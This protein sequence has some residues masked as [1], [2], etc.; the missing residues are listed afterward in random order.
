M[1]GPKRQHW[2]PCAYLQFFAVDANYKGRK[3]TVFFCDGAVSKASSAEALGA[4]KWAYSKINPAVDHLFN[5]IESDYPKIVRKT[6]DDKPL[7]MKEKLGLFLTVFDLNHR[8]VAF[9]NKSSKE[10]FDVY[11]AISRSFIED[12]SKEANVAHDDFQGLQD[13]LVGTWTVAVV[14]PE[15][16]E[17]FITSDYPSIVFT[18]ATKGRPTLA[19]LPAHPSFAFVIFDNEAFEQV[20]E[21]ISDDA[22]GLLNALHCNLSIRHIFADHDFSESPE[23]FE[24]IKVIMQKE[25]PERWIDD[26]QWTTGY[27][28][29]ASPMISKLS[30]LKRLLD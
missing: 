25:K 18:G 8:N 27:I 22:L 24:S 3:S 10:R 13:Y 30:F 29:T 6:L 26:V 21:Q 5:V 23:D 19:I 9:E 12:F 28:S 17:K 11:R 14:R 20:T 4:E 7:T 1:S 16:D 15:T 2:V